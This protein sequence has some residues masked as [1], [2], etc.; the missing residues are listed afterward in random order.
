MPCPCGT[1]CKCTSQNPSG[2]CSCGTSC[3]CGSTK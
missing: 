3:K 2:N 1:G